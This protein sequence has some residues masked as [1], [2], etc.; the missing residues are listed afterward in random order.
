[1]SN[2]TDIHSL[3]NFNPENYTF[4]GWMYYGNDTE[5]AEEVNSAE[6]R[7]YIRRN[8]HVGIHPSMQCDHCGAHFS[9]GAIFEHSDGGY[10]KVGHSCANG[11]FE[12]SD[13]FEYEHRFL[14]S[15][16]SSHRQRLA[17]LE[18]FAR[19]LEANP[20]IADAFEWA[21]EHADD[22]IGAINYKV[23]TILDIRNRDGRRCTMSERQEA[24][25]LKLHK[26]GIE[27]LAEH[28]EEMK[29]SEMFE[30][31]Q[32]GRYEVSGEVL[33]FKEVVSGYGSTMRMLVE[34]ESGHRVFGTLPSSID[35]AQKGDKIVFTAAFT[36]KP[37][38]NDF[39]WFTRP[40]K[41]RI[42]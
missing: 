9:Y 30:P 19:Y 39:G 10:I 35:D 1:M 5:L 6:T 42:I 25:V 31:L 27:S 29:R 3:K 38:A 20:E 28:E 8:T 40:T 12:T 23:R 22:D 14:R 37:N 4:V 15:R 36:P 11:R 2:R 32:E 26:E 7:E 24:F 21:Q 17:E 13:R 33:G 41:A 18:K 16:V 34:L